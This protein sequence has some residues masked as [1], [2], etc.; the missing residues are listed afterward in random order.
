MKNFKD[1]FESL[2]DKKTYNE[3][4]TIQ[5]DDKTINIVNCTPHSVVVNGVT[6]PKSNSVPRIRVDLID[7]DNDLFKMEKK[8]QIEDL[9]S[10][11]K[12]TLYIVSAIVFSS[13][14]RKDLIAPNTGKANRDDKGNIISVPN[15][16][17]KWDKIEQIL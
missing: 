15:F 1:Y 5:I 12:G 10:K 3:S 17:C 4:N 11:E 13:S 9:P 6:Y 2:Q 14:D 7:T 16:I 8:G